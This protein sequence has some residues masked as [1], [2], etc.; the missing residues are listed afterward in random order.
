[1]MW[2]IDTFCVPPLALLQPSAARA[3]L[4][5]RSR[6]AAAARANAKMLGRRGLQYSWESS[7]L[8]GEEAMPVPGFAS[9]YE[10][11][12][13]F[14]VAVA[15][16]T[17]ANATGSE[18]YLRTVA[19]PVI[20][21]VADWVTSRVEHVRG[22]YRFPRS[23]GIAERSVAVDDDAYTVMASKVVLRTAVEIARRFGEPS[24]PDWQPV[25]AGLRLPINAQG[26]LVGHAGFRKDED[27]GATPDPLAGFFP[28]WFDAEPD[29]VARTIR[30]YL[31][32][33]PEYIGEPMLSP[34]YG[35]WAAWLGDRAASL[36]LFEQGYADLVTGRFRQT[37][38]H[39]VSR[40]PT[41][42]PAGPFA[43]N[44]GG[45]LSGLLYGLP[46]IR[47]GAADPGTEWPSRP[48]VLPA[49]WRRIE[50]ERAWVHGRPAHLVAEHGAERAVLDVSSPPAPGATYPIPEIARL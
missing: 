1:V 5:Y 10:D 16:A 3:L 15:F 7:P 4:E 34:L 11:H 25:E 49:G 20:A 24:N 14:D 23:L 17:L 8:Q 31:E 45:F 18:A 33:A 42:A 48:V 30:Y 37:M 28:L 6:T 46:G 50:V 26:V 21:G 13:S 9:M 44:I 32:L 35:V 38:E 29:L 41:A 40:Y 19:A 12:G 36:R 47:V 22:G 39:T 2:D 43:A 27:K